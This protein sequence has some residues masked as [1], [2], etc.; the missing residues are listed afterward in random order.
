MKLMTLNGVRFCT[1]DTSHL[2]QLAPVPVLL[3]VPF[4]KIKDVCIDT[5]TAPWPVRQVNICNT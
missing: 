4:R 1:L 2:S 5:A 3:S